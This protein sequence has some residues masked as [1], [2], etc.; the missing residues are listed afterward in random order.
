VRLETS[1]RG[2][3]V[4]RA[5]AIPTLLLPLAL[6][7]QQIYRTTDEQG[8]VIFTDQPPAG[9]DSVERVE[10]NPTNTAEPP[11]VT[12]LPAPDRPPQPAALEAVEYQVSID[13]PDDETTIAMGPG[14]FTVSARVEPP[15]A[16][17]HSLQLQMDGEDLGP[18]QRSS[19][20]ELT[21]VFR[22]AHEITVSVVDK[23]GEMLTTSAPV[24]V[25][26]LRPSSNFRN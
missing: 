10:L 9:S 8:N 2:K 4:I 22:G 1:V 5:L 7:A 6:A 17:G 13:R 16:A 12:P 19:I 15:P 20:W 25:Y 26:V 11:T 18:P 24:R 14:N 23:E 3:T 21:N